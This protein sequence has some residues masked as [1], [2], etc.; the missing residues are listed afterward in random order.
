MSNL[1][2]KLSPVLY[3]VARVTFGV[4]IA[5][6]GYPKL[7]NLAGF[8]ENVGKMFPLPM[9]LGPIAALSELLGGILVAIGYKTRLACVFILFTMLGAAF[10]VHAADPFQKKEFALLFAVLSLVF[11]AKGS[12]KF[13]LD[14]DQQ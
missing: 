11:M 8:I 7:M 12:G 2:R 9:V 10:V 5:M 4:F 14:K 1:F 13:S 3:L 6:H